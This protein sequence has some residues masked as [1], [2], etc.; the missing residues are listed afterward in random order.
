M[1]SGGGRGGSDD[2]GG[3]VAAIL[4]HLLLT[5]WLLANENLDCNSSPEASFSSLADSNFNALALN[6]YFLLNYIN[7]FL[8]LKY[9]ALLSAKVQVILD[10]K[11]IHR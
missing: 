5:W 3:G 8:N 2:R 9:L 4:V 11:L 1:S 7:I 10:R 6:V